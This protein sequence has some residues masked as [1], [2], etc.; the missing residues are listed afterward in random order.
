MNITKPSESWEINP[1]QEENTHL[2]Q[3]ISLLEDEL[4][5]F[6]RTRVN[7]TDIVKQVFEEAYENVVE[8]N[9]KLRMLLMNRTT[10]PTLLAAL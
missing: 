1:L 8:E 2:K 3:K 9:K 10:A 4:D 5:K 6:K 7:Q